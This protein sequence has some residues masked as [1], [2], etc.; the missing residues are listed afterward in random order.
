[1]IT[2]AI[3]R[4]I[5]QIISV[6]ETSSL[7]PKYGQVTVLPDGPGGV[8]QITYGAH[9]TTEN[10]HLKELLTNY[11][12][13]RGK[14]AADIRP[15]LPKVGKYV[16]HSS[17]T[18]KSLLRLAGNDELMQDLQESLFE[19]RYWLPAYQFFTVNGFVLP[20][21][22]AVIYD[23]YIH[24]GGLPSW[25]RNKFAEVP[26]AKGGDEKAYI[27]AYVNARDQW[28]EEH[29]NKILRN[30]DYRTDVWKEQI[31]NCNWNL[32]SPVVV[33][34]NSTKQNSWITIS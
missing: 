17:E 16:L 28:L 31:L 22:M 32:A 18:F 23:S 29:T 11:V 26:P 20:L 6:F 19:K 33:K 5:K 27:N 1:M 25:L 34:F 12:N 9:Q 21:S 3:K 2:D 4:K 10:S 30:T 13:G 14:Y 8:K 7:N 24:S 15:Y